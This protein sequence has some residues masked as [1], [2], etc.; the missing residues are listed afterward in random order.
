MEANELVP[1]V[2]VLVVD[3]Q[4]LFR[5]AAKA[6]VERLPGFAL[7]GESASGEE[8]VVSA[9]ML[10]PDLVLM[11]INMD[12]ID[13]IEATSLITARDPAPLVVLVSTYTREDLPA[14]ARTSGATA[15]VNKDD[16]SP[17]VI[18]RIWDNRGRPDPAFW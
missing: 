6:V 15:Y 9:Q 14:R 3:D 17:S 11:D 8:A 5:R 16:L 18:R 13:G 12:G 2:T 7:A 4:P 1:M 10:R